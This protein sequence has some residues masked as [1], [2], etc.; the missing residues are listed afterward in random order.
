MGDRVRFL[1]EV[2]GGKVKRM[3]DN[4]MVEILTEDGWGIPYLISDLVIIPDDPD[5]EPYKS[6]SNPVVFRD[7]QH[8]NQSVPLSQ[9]SYKIELLAV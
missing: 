9:E 1:N 2:G 3:L 5:L 8:T 4:Q 6:E 7:V